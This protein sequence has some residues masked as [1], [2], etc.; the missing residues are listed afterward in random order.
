MIK[1][2]AAQTENNSSFFEKFKYD[3]MSFHGK[4]YRDIVRV[5]ILGNARLGGPA[6]TFLQ[7]V[8][9]CQVMRG[10]A[11]GKE[12]EIGRERFVTSVQPVRLGNIV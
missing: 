5:S 8:P 6:R 2:N 11:R 4:K 12:T 10:F 1:F 3:Q 9:K 7:R